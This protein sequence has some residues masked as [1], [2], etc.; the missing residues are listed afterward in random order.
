MRKIKLIM[1]LTLVVF[2][3]GGCS[4]EGNS[5]TEDMM[6][7]EIYKDYTFEYI[8][9]YDYDN[10]YS[11]YT[12]GLV[13]KFKGT[14]KLIFQLGSDDVGDIVSEGSYT[15]DPINEIECYLYKNG[16]KKFK[17]YINKNEGNL[18]CYDDEGKESLSQVKGIKKGTASYNTRETI[19][20]Y[21]FVCPNIY[22]MIDGCD[23]YE[24]IHNNLYHETSEI[25]LTGD[26][27]ESAYIR[28]S[29]DMFVE[30][31]DYEDSGLI[32]RYGGEELYYR[33]A[34]VVEF[35]VDEDSRPEVVF[36]MYNNVIREITYDDN[37]EKMYGDEII[38]YEECYIYHQSMSYVEYYIELSSENSSSIKE[39]LNSFHMAIGYDAA[40]EDMCLFYRTWK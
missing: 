17:I 30:Y 39:L 7:N 19:I 22:G 16:V 14:D 1:L 38:G 21:A 28:E 5:I 13:L 36:D 26:D 20:E 12:E 2:A 34:F 37:G 8:P 4:S 15:A 11:D 31:E 25:I 33:S 18:T 6:H 9:D 24:I 29:N 35:A 23:S 10:D 27:V 3:L 40:D 32:I